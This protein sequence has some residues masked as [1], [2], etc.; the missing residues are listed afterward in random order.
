MR[1]SKAF[2]T[3]R[4]LLGWVLFAWVGFGGLGLFLSLVKKEIFLPPLFPISWAVLLSPQCCSS[5]VLAFAKDLMTLL[6]LPSQGQAAR[7][8][9]RLRPSSVGVACC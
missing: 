7:R 4:D 8:C 9:C 2:L 6:L 5:G 1:L 3:V